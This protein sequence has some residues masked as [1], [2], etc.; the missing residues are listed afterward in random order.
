MNGAKNLFY[1]FSNG[2]YNYGYATTF[3]VFVPFFL[4]LTIGKGYI[5]LHEAATM[6]K[7]MTGLR[8]EYESWGFKSNHD[9]DKKVDEETPGFGKRIFYVIQTFASLLPGLS[10][11]PLPK[12]VAMAGSDSYKQTLLRR[13][14][15]ELFGENATQFILQLS[16]K[17][18][19]SDTEIV[20]IDTLFKTIF[21]NLT[22]ASSLFGLIMRS[23][24]V[25]LQLA[26]KDKY[27]VRTDPYTCLKV[28]LIVVPLMFT[29]I[30]P[31][32]LAYAICFGSSFPLFG[33][34]TIENEKG[35]KGMIN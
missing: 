19:A 4:T 13:K 14:M 18:S 8:K 22:I 12:N 10:W 30:L 25:Y 20:S 6:H 7:F 11:I 28:K 15:Y 33:N 17:L 3:F 24:I 31:R 29:A 16:I 9:I 32:I 1:H 5:E 21:T 27:G 26:S 35:D 23:T 34:G 2:H